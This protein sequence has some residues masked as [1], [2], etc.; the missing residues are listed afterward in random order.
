MSA[1]S[2]PRSRASDFELAPS[3][4]E[5]AGRLWGAAEEGGARVSGQSA[6]G[7]G[8]SSSTAPDESRWPAE[9]RRAAGGQSA[10][11]GCR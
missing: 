9:W 3:G 2:A 1:H 7:V 11:K 4:R 5:S 10:S 6:L 8:L